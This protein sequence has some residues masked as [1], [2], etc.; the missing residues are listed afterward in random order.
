MNIIIVGAGEVGWH[1]AEELSGKSHNICVIESSEQHVR[2]LNDKLDVRALVGTGTSVNILEEA[3]VA[4]CDL[5]LSLTNDDN[6]NFV[7]ASMAKALGAKLTIARVHA[8]VQREEWLFDYKSHFQI[9]HLFSSER[10]AA[11]ELAKFIRNP[12]SLLAEEIARGRIELQRVMVSAKS[13]CVGRSLQD[14]KFP[15]RTRIGLIKRDGANFIPSASDMLLPE[16]VVTMFGEPRKL[17]D[18]ICTLQPSKNAVQERKVVIFGG[19]EAGFAL[20]QMLEAG[21]RFKVRVFEVNAKRCQMLAEQ[22]QSTVI[23]NADATSIQHLR[24]ERVG[25]ADFFVAV[26]DDDED[27]VMTCLQANHLGTKYCLAVIHRADYADAI[28]RLGK[29]IGI[30]G[31]VSPR[32]ASKRDLLRFVTETRYHLVAK[33]DD[34]AEVI[35]SAI[36][37]KSRVAGK[38]V[39][40]V[41]WP[42]ASGLVALI[43]GPHAIVPS[44]EDVINPGDTLFA[45]VSQKSKKE[46]VKLLSP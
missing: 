3:D 7:A 27:N 31:A 9:D 46:L 4:N 30:L 42:E 8:G 5:M 14:L 2:N 37:A 6:T 19:T 40:E 12:E 39:S 33:L 11:V 34:D 45:L 1:L 44:G 32:E 25:D 13:K 23:I 41:E 38:R 28:S 35:Q 24:E 10:L 18:V 21:A 22:L 26:T 20:A 17:S 16:D 43:H 29:Q 36:S 15:P